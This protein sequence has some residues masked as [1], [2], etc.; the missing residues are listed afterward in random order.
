MKQMSVNTCER[1]KARRAKWTVT[2][3]QNKDDKK[4]FRVRNPD[5]RQEPVTRREQSAY[6]CSLPLE[7]ASFASEIKKSVKRML[8]V[9]QR[10]EKK[11][12]RKVTSGQICIG[13][14]PRTCG[15]GSVC[16]CVAGLKAAT[17]AAA[18]SWGIEINECN[19]KQTA[20]Q[21]RAINTS[22][23]EP[24]CRAEEMED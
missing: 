7:I 9:S 17:V 10:R 14:C 24:R 22:R 18:A 21:A 19:Q 6:C 23:A 11:N 12:K 8:T 20:S 4:R 16:N 15:G 5:A 3:Q 2:R 13:A 1:F